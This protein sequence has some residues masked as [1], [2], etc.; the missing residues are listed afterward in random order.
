VTN[1]KRVEEIRFGLECGHYC[2]E[3][4]V[5]FLLSE[6]DR[7]RKVVEAAQ[8]VA[9]AG[10][11]LATSYPYLIADLRR[12]LKDAPRRT[13]METKWPCRKCDDDQDYGPGELCTYCGAKGD[14][15]I[16]D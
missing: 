4:T 2:N 12:A 13:S 6:L 14:L 11:L 9:D 16:N 8:K 5:R 10:A 3:E 7:A 1:D 15:T